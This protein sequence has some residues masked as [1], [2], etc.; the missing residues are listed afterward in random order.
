MAQ[1][2]GIQTPSGFGGLMRFNEEFESKF[3]LTPGQI[4]GFLVLIVLFSIALH[5]FWALPTG[6]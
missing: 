2:Q 3:K 1:N 5:V 4:I 6:A